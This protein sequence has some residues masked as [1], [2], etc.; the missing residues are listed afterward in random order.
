MIEDWKRRWIWTSIGRVGRDVG[1]GRRLEGT[2]LLIV[3]I[4]AVL[5]ACS[6]RHVGGCSYCTI[7]S[8]ES[9]RR[10]E[11]KGRQLEGLDPTLLL[12]G[13]D[14]T[15]LLDGDWKFMFL[16]VPI[17]AVVVVD[18]SDRCCCCC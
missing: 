9:R 11:G 18:C 3:P 15:S 13:L 16:I 14:P 8:I 1:F 4:D 17:D 2:L 12:E 6:V 10:L 5:V 7:L